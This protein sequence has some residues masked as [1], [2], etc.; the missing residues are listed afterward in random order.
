[1]GKY[2]SW[3]DDPGYKEYYKT[4][5][6]CAKCKEVVEVSDAVKYRW[7]FY[8]KECAPP[9]AKFKH[10]CAYCGKPTTHAKWCSKECKHLDLEK[11][12]ARCVVCGAVTKWTK[13]LVKITGKKYPTCSEECKSKWQ[14]SKEY[15]DLRYKPFTGS[16]SYFAS[17]EFKKQM[18]SGLQSN[19]LY[20][21]AVRKRG[22][23]ISEEEYNERWNNIKNP[24]YVMA[25]CSCNGVYIPDM[26]KAHFFAKTTTEIKYRKI[27]QEL[28]PEHFKIKTSVSIEQLALYQKL[29]YNYPDLEFRL[30]VRGPKNPSTSGVFRFDIGCFKDGELQCAI[31]YDGVWY[32][33]RKNPRAFI[34][35]NLTRD[36]AKNLA[37]A[38]LGIKLFRVRSD[39]YESDYNTLTNYLGGL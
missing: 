13:H 3:V 8:H 38:D 1:M 18:S 21:V 32:H 27:L 15:W 30:E 6:I 37:C 24:A 28:D 33:T 35:S 39:H 19:Q 12:R 31:E 23:N 16:N 14:N 25:H 22:C 9:N 17:D 4:H 26:F 7:A 10:P 34:E 5:K 2:P 11:E 36:Q 29:V 20:K